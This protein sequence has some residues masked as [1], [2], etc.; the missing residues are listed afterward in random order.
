MQRKRVLRIIFTVLITIYIL[1][2]AGLYFFQKKLIFHPMTLPGN[3][4]FKYDGPFQEI[5]LKLNDKETLNA[6]LF[7]SPA[8]KGIVVFFHGNGGNMSRLERKTTL[9]TQQGWD[10][11][12]MDYPG[13][14]K[15]V[16]PLTEEAIYA[17]ALHLYELARS[18]YSPDSI[19][20]CGHSLGTGVA[21][22]LASVRDCRRLILEAPFYNLT[23]IAVHTAPIY[24]VGLMLDFHFPSNEYLP[25]VTAPITILHGTDDKTVPI[26]SGKKLEKLLKPGDRFVTIPGAGHNNLEQYPLFRQTLDSL[27]R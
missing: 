2:G 6:V 27:L 24:P 10:V 25:K 4:V 7:K 12:M 13:Y 19:I 21:S 17:D 22:E 26:S 15:S 16:G 3:F 5:N 18:R 8:P 23:D 1:G 14:G 20:I 9:F 11:L